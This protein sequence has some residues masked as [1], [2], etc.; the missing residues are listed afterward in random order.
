MCP[1]PKGLHP[2]W[3][4]Q[5][6]IPLL[7]LRKYKMLDLQQ[8]HG[9]WAQDLAVLLCSCTPEMRYFMSFL[10][11]D[12]M[13]RLSEGVFCRYL[14]S[15]STKTWVVWQHSPGASRALFVPQP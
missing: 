3:G 8:G 14:R 10:F 6:V 15:C 11:T 9:L 2:H 7:S 12:I 1:F 13:M 4:E 5:G